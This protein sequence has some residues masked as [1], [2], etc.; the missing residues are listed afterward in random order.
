MIYADYNGSAP[1]CPEVIDYLTERLQKGPF[2]NPNAIHA[3]GQRNMMAIKRAR[4]A[5]AEILGAKPEQLFFNS[6][7]T[8]GI[9]SIF[10]S[11]LRKNNSNK[12][13]LIAISGIEH[14]AI[15]NL[16]KHYSEFGHEVYYIKTR[17]NGQVDLE[18]FN[19]L[20]KTRKNELALVSVMAANNETGV[21]QP[22]QEIHQACN[23][24]DVPYF[25][26][27]TQYIGKT[28]FNFA[29]SG[30]DYAV[31]S[32][33]KIGALTGVG[34]LL[35][36]E[37]NKF[38][39]NIYGGG[40][41][42]GIRGGTQNYIGIETMAVALEALNKNWQKLE[43]LAAKRDEFESQLQL[44][45]PRLQI[46][47]KDSP[48]LVGT[49]YL[50]YPGIH[51]QALQ[52]ELEAKDIFVTTS[53]ACS[54]NEPVTSKV[55]KAMNVTDEVGRGA[56]RVSLGLC[57]SPDFY[58]KILECLIAAIQKLSKIDSF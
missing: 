44:K 37:P 57:S 51:G 15:I 47:G 43:T 45:F 26:D 32:G 48:R 2:A 13:P 3:L 10:Y 55:L 33:H 28:P 34:V 30:L 39:P 7:A 12:K 22:Y 1:F 49:T 54:D 16:G 35:V 42:S 6:G 8:E 25:C 52:I 9:N 14:S 20:L 29:K 41:E 31:A 53:S 27:T 21:I 56:L 50:S 24:A 38:L 5:C 23:E 4:K 58:D 36:K 46:L 18:D 40:Q 11:L 19:H 17:P